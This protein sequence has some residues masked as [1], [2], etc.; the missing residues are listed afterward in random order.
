M[1]VLLQQSP[2]FNMA[3]SIER[4]MGDGDKDEMRQR[5]AAFQNAKLK[6]AIPGQR[7]GATARQPCQEKM[8]PTIRKAAPPKSIL[9]KKSKPPPIRQQVENTIV[10]DIDWKL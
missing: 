4:M 5:L 8:V 6:P 10:H 3:I 7:K 2:F 9:K 1:G